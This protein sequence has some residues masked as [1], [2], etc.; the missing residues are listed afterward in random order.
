MKKRPVLGVLVS[1][2]AI[3]GA[4]Q[5]L[6]ELLRRLDRDRFEPRLYCL[7]EKGPVG[8]EIE[9]LGVPVRSG[10]GG[11]PL[12]T[13]FRLHRAFRQ[14]RLDALLLINHRNCLFYGVP[15]ARLA[16][17]RAI[18]NWQNETFK[19]HRHHELYMFV[20]RGVV[21]GLDALAAASKGHAGYLVTV[22]GVPVRKVLAI[23]NGV[24]VAAF[25]SELSPQEARSRLHL[26]EAGKTVGIIAALRPDKAHE[27]FLQA[28][29]R[30]AAVAP[31]VR[32][33]VVG[34]G[35]QRAFLEGEAARL[36]LGGQ[37]RFLGFRRD[38]PD[39]LA[40]MD[41]VVLSSDPRQETLSVAALEA[42]SAGVPMVATRVGFMDEIVRDGV[43]GR[44]VPPRDPEALAGA[45]L[46]L[47]GDD[48]ARREMGRRA[49]AL[50][51]QGHTLSGMACG[52]EGLF[53]E[54]LA[55]RPPRRNLCPLSQRRVSLG[56]YWAETGQWRLLHR[57]R[58]ELA[59]VEYVRLGDRARRVLSRLGGLSGW[60]SAACLAVKQ[61]AR[62][63]RSDAILS[64][65]LPLGVCTGLVLRLV[66]TRFRPVH[67]VRDFH[68]NLS[69]TDA[70][71]RLRL[72]VLRLA[73]PGIDALWCTSEA[74][75]AI[76]AEMF[77]LPGAAVS[78]YPDEPPSQYLDLPDVPC[79]GYV[80][81]YG[82]SD[83][84]FEGLVASAG[85]IGR[86]IVILSQTFAFPEP[87]PPNVRA[88]RTRVSEAEMVGLLQAAAVVVVP[89]RDRR[90]AAGQNGFL[91]S[92]AL[93]RP[94]VAAANVAVLEFADH[95]EEALFYEPGDR[96]GLVRAVRAVLD[97]PDEAR[98]MGRRGRERRRRML[99]EQPFRFL[100]LLSKAIRLAGK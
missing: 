43:T 58:R 57:L 51:G 22:E 31:D 13:I 23:P 5:L 98:E 12:R 14:D 73:L 41:L 27:V 87:L 29:A 56:L 3:G 93:G 95:G 94:V 62:A 32:F 99:A 2:L 21:W 10:L 4:E 34:D 17:V 48:A 91:E 86:E 28:A 53:T 39:I 49:R 66:P 61:V 15:A 79:A 74:E 85:A 18:V 65:A 81:A 96:E 36:G 72:A 84:D 54:L 16:G 26:S 76:Y 38:V 97:D 100:A 30:V 40:A 83:R 67:I 90:L 59:A 45:M 11:G 88:V 89:T 68:L 92:M 64:W 6:L 50:V 71:Y 25:R 70:A 55:G 75:R 80:F 1:T 24:D 60:A 52:F 9:A 20:R 35:P 46:D 63:W 82:N 78:F 47:L 8:L 69:R 19:R 7:G 44:L 33:L 77:G 37:V 42:L